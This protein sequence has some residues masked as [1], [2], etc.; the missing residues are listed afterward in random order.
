MRDNERMAQTRAVQGSGGAC[1][2]RTAGELIRAE[3]EPAFMLVAPV[4]IARI[5]GRGSPH[6]QLGRWVL[7]EHAL[8]AACIVQWFSDLRQIAREQLKEEGMLWWSPPVATLLRS[9]RKGVE[10]MAA[11]LGLEPV[12]IDS[13]LQDL[14][15]VFSAQLAAVKDNPSPAIAALPAIAKAA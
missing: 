11:W 7:P 12:W 1:A 5:V 2:A 8:L 13:M 15:L 4:Q 6:Y 9:D 14:G 10:A 3:V